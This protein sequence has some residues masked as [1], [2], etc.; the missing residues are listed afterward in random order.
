[1]ARLGLALALLALAGPARAVET[2]HS[3]GTAI[4]G[5]RELPKRLVI[6]PWKPPRVDRLPIRP[7]TKRL[8]EALQPID[9]RVMRRLINYEKTP[10]DPGADP[11]HT[12]KTTQEAH[13]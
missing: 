10:V 8:D 11:R 5:D 13:P 3:D 2:V 6:V 4:I 9:R 12:E 7:Y 1:M